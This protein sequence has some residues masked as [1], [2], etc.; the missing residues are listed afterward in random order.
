MSKKYYAKFV[1][2]VPV[3]SSLKSFP[4]NPGYPYKELNIPNCCESQDKTVIYISDYPTVSC[5]GGAVLSIN[6]DVVPVSGT[7]PATSGFASLADYAAALNLAYPGVFSFE[8]INTNELA[9]TILVPFSTFSYTIS[10]T[11]E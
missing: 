5:I 7:P 1:N 11:C 4:N 8:A 6:G 10:L 9:I 3:E 2:G